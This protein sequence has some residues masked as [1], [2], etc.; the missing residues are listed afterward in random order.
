MV[1][2]TLMVIYFSL[3]HNKN[4][5]VRFLT[6]STAEDAFDRLPTMGTIKHV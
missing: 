5:T 3:R 6:L 4:A 1:L 2:M